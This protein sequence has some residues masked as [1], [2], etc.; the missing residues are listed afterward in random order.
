LT[1]RHQREPAILRSLTVR[2]AQR[3]GFE[4]RT[5]ELDGARLQVTQ[6]GLFSQRQVRV[7]AVVLFGDRQ[8]L[9]TSSWV[10]AAFAVL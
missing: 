10:P 5:F 9:R 3:R 6:A 1:R 7:P 8:E 4:R 2:L